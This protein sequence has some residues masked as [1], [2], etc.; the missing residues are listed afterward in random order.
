MFSKQYF[1]LGFAMFSM[2]FG[3][4]NLIFPASL[5]IITGEKW[6]FALLGFLTTG[7]G[8]TF[9]GVFALSKTEGSPFKF[10]E[11]VSPKFSFIFNSIIILSIG[12]LLALPRTGAVTFEMAVLPFAP[13][14]NPWVF[15]IFYFG[16][17]VFLAIKPSSMLDK[18]GKLLSPM[19]LLTLSLIIGVGI[20]KPFG[21]IV[22]TVNL[23]QG[24]YIK[25]F[26]EG[27]QTMDALGS[28]IIAV[29]VIDIIKARTKEKERNKALLYTSIIAG[30]LMALVYGGLMYL[31][32][33]SGSLYIGEN[34]SR[35]LLLTN[36]AILTLG[37]LGQLVLAILVAFA[38]LTTS[39]GL[40]ATAGNFFS[41]HTSFTYEK[42][43]IAS[44][45]FSLFV[46][47]LGVDKIVRISV[48]LLVLMYP[49][50]IVLIVLN[51]FSNIFKIKG[52]YIGAVIGASL[53]SLIEAL[54]I[55]GIQLDFI[56]NIYNTLPLAKAGYAFLLP[57]IIFS[58]IFT[59]IIRDE[60]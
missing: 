31:G 42:V 18:L 1:V 51:S 59:L 60:T 38:C 32:A 23:E 40:V 11:K 26:F 10:A 58:I 27:Y 3:A 9:L 35:T 48:P 19:I 13:S 24:A 43:V 36:L 7:V 54:G 52:T 17:T 4:G 2:F 39:V 50:C 56:N 29:L 53:V 47:N 14:F 45:V 21:N 6:F 49:I 20:F 46:S 44:A 22:N 33:K 25:G 37:N 15:G 57:A 30:S 8:L 55:I 28:I 5:G 41:K 16:L 12:P 34:I